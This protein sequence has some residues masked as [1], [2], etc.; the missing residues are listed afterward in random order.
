MGI[1]K[2]NWAFSVFNLTEETPKEVTRLQGIAKGFFAVVTG[3]TWYG[4]DA[5][6]A[7]LVALGAVLVDTILGCLYV[8]KVQ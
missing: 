5:N 8:E 3:A 1:P 7:L 6:H 4:A 2:F